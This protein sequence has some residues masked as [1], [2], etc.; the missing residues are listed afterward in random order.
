MV[1]MLHRTVQRFF[2]H[3]ALERGAALAFYVGLSFGPLVMVLITFSGWLWTAD[4]LNAALAEWLPGT[5]GLEETIRAYGALVEASAD[6]W[7]LSLLNLGVLL[8]STLGLFT[9]LKAS[10]NAIW[11]VEREP[12]R[13][14]GGWVRSRATALLSVIVIEELIL[15]SLLISWLST[16]LAG[17]APVDL[18][19]DPRL[20]SGL[21][22]V[23][24]GLMY[25]LVFTVVFTWVPDAKIRW[26]DALAGAV[27]TAVLF[28]LAKE[29]LGVYFAFGGMEGFYGPAGSLVLLQLWA[30]YTV[31]V[32]FFGAEFTAVYARR[33]GE[34]I[35]PVE[36]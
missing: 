24:S 34:T 1:D 21:N 15:L 17:R 33:F 25:V 9:Q 26:R 7:D 11:E 10:M 18:A 8:L 19:F 31:L 36:A 4:A 2:R 16:L 28:S 27:F 30:Y 22:V 20:V 35:R 12:S 3:R 23:V 14:W 32:L 13:D 29:L 6:R 5:P